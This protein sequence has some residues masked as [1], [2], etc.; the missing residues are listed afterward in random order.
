MIEIEL[1]IAPKTRFWF[2][3]KLVSPQTDSLPNQAFSRSYYVW[4]KETFGPSFQGKKKPRK[5]TDMRWAVHDTYIKF[6]RKEDA[7]LFLLKWGG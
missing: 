6:R 5:W 3:V 2:T 1:E 7:M 4:C